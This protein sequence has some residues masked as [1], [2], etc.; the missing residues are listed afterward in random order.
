M[1][2]YIHPETGEIFGGD[3]PFNIGGVKYPGGWI[4]TLT[5]AEMAL[6][7]INV[8]T[9]PPE[10]IVITPPMVNDER[11]RRMR[12]S[13][14]FNGKEYDCDSASLQRITGAATLAGFWLGGGGDPA[15]VLWHGGATP[16]RWIASDN[17]IVEMDAQTVFAFGQAASANETAHIFAARVIKDLDPIPAD[18]ADDSRWP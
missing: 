16:F 13:F 10:E 3:A 12:G 1:T 18:Y 6:M 14:T 5:G 4:K 9:P 15:S 17:S 8:Y 7:G 2:A 11:D